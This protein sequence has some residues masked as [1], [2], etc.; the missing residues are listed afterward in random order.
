MIREWQ[1]QW[2]ALIRKMKYASGK[3]RCKLILKLGGRIIGVHRYFYLSGYR[4]DL[5]AAQKEEDD[6]IFR[7]FKKTM[8]LQVSESHMKKPDTYLALMTESL[9]QGG[10]EEVV[11]TLAIEWN[12]KGLSVKVL[13]V[14]SGG[15]IAEELSL[16]GI[17]V[18]TFHGKKAEFEKYISKTPP[19]LVNSHYVVRFLD[20]LNKYGVPVVEVIHN[21]YVFLSP[22]RIREIIKNEIYI[23]KYIA[24]SQIA[25]EVFLLKFPDVDNKKIEIIGN[26][27][28]A[29]DI[30]ERKNATFRKEHG[31]SGDAMLF[32]TAGSIH[33]RK[34]QAGIL[35]AWDVIRRLGT[36][37]AVLVLAGEG[38]D[39]EYERKILSMIQERKLEGS[40][41]LIGYCSDMDSLLQEADV[42]LLDSYYE[43]WSMAATMALRHGVPLI[44]S[45]CGSGVELVA[46]GQ[47]GILVDNPMRDLE[48]YSS[49]ELYDRMLG[50]IN[51][52]LEQVVE[53]ILQMMNSRQEWRLKK[54][55]IINYAQN[56][57]S[58]E[59]M[60]DQYL[61]VFA[62][63]LGY[64]ED[65]WKQK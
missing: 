57:F 2:K 60:A 8:G 13:C 64:G 9:D 19:I 12:R 46:R 16:A 11:R 65:K 48:Q 59:K 25:K 20:I 49:E 28:E 1:Y 45:R 63:V 3:E 5:I 50:G 35:R 15:S 39:L 4:E 29:G 33:P 34:N 18:L 17:E 58:V 14:C 36:D 47:N 27:V 32:V 40:V 62:N 52:N 38:A 24:V 53:A 41:R 55:N 42:F 54:Q 23:K 43:G 44:H 61:E 26:G 31:I 21:M 56:N 6:Q 30:V 7:K 10:L 37:P 51:D 22:G